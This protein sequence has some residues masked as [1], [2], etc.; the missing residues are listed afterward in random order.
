MEGKISTAEGN[1]QTFARPIQKFAAKLSVRE[2]T[3]SLFAAR[4]RMAAGGISKRE[5]KIGGFGLK[6]GLVE[7][8]EVSPDAVPARTELYTN[9]IGGFI[10]R[11]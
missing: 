4:E 3:I 9:C 10:R 5:G 2:G 8:K 6:G 11:I 1:D 7:W